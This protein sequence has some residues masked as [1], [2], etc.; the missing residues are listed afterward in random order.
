MEG[1]KIYERFKTQ[2]TI[3]ASVCV[4]F[5]FLLLSINNSKWFV[6]VWVSIGLRFIKTIRIQCITNVTLIL[7]SMEILDFDKWREKLKRQYLNNNKK[8]HNHRLVLLR[9]SCFNPVCVCIFFFNSS[10][11]M[12]VAG[13]MVKLNVYSVINWWFA[14]TKRN[15]IFII[16][17]KCVSIEDSAHP[18]TIICFDFIARTIWH[19]CDSDN[20][21]YVCTL[22]NVRDL[23]LY[24]FNLWIDLIIS[25]IY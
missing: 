7:D 17:W 18:S 3:A 2:P 16:K 14:L 20:E 10:S 12:F 6:C 1:T 5:S 24:L 9:D 21:Q 15:F 11:F 22:K 8:T 25:T 4:F 13:K 23:R 19:L